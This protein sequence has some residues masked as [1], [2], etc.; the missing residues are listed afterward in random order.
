VLAAAIFD[1]TD[2][3]RMP[4]LGYVGCAL[5]AAAAVAGA[6]AVSATPHDYSF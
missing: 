4:W 2:R 3:R 6:I 1:Q 5:L